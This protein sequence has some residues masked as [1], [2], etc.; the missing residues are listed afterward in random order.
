VIEMGFTI[1]IVDDS[2]TT[3]AIIKRAIAATGFA[4]E[5][6]IEAANG[7]LA[8]DALDG[9]AVDL[10]FADLHMPEMDGLE[11]T[12]RI[13]ANPQTVSIPVV[14]ISA[15]PNAERIA[16]LQGQGIRGYL[17]KPFTPEAVRQVLQDVIGVAH[18]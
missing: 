1:L 12:R 2:A 6:Y 10:V 18:A 4:V 9:S 11:M 7:K 15:E 16:Q 13:Q 5:R 14:I 8:L 17:R 3:R